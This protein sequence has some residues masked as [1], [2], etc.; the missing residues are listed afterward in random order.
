MKFFNLNSNNI[1]I[2]MPTIYAYEITNLII[3][4]IIVTNLMS[5]YKMDLLLWPTAYTFVTSD[6]TW[7]LY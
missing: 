5:N 3:I 2:S 7:K 1:N 4:I 6:S